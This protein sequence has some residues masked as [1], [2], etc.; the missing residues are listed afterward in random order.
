MM[1]ALS[2]PRCLYRQPGTRPLPGGEF[3]I[4][5][6]S[7][8]DWVLR[9]PGGCRSKRQWGSTGTADLSTAR[10]FPEPDSE[11]SAVRVVPRCL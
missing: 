7:E 10:A 6:G 8:G 3:S 1:P 2:T 11:R 4:D 9:N 5:Y